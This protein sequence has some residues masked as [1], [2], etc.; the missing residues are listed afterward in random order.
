[1]DSETLRKLHADYRGHVEAVRDES[2][3]PEARETAQ[4]EMLESR[5]RLDEALIVTQ[6]E[7]EDAERSDAVE[8]RLHAM[9]LV[10]QAAKPAMSLFPEEELRSYVDG[11]VNQVKFHLPSGFERRT[12]TDLTPSDT[13]TYSSRTIPQKWNDMVQLF[14]IAYSGVLRAGPRIL[15]TSSGEQI[16]WPTLTTDMTATAGTYGTAASN[17]AYP[18]FGTTPLN[19]YRVEVWTP[20]ADELLRDSGVDFESLIGELAGRALA[21]KAATYYGDPDVGTG[22]SLPASIQISATSAVTAA[23]TT[24]VTVDEIVELFY[25]VLPEYRAVGAFV[26]NSAETLRL[27]QA[28]SGD[29]QYL[30]QPSRTAAEPDTFL[31]KPWHEDAYFDASTTG[32]MVVCFGD[33]QRA[34]IIRRIGGMEVS[35]SRDFAFT[36]FE[37]TM[38]AA[39]WHDAAGVDAIAVKGI[40]TA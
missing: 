18:V 30:W 21:A 3:S 1:M 40:T 22:S 27:A 26:A 2:A 10:E 19:S 31:G 34:Y 17:S 39:I 7:R 6:E 9:G 36:S 20:I 33:W 11:K 8:R 13:T 14:A 25:S 32:N 38:R 12:T 37:T 16:N 15:N 4:V 5:H 28:K 24:A 35:F 29:G 23:S